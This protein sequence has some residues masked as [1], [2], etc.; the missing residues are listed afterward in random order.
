MNLKSY[1]LLLIISLQHSLYCQPKGIYVLDSDNGTYRDANIRNYSFVD[2]YVWRTSWSEMES[3]KN[4]FNFD[5]I[6]HIVKKLDAINKKLTIL[7]GAYSIEPSYIPATSG[8]VNY[9]FTNP[10]NNITSTRAVPYDSYLME[11]FQLFLTPLANH[12]IYSISTSSMVALKDHPVLSN[13]ATNIPGLGAIRN[14]NGQNISLHTS[15]PNYTRNLF[16]Q[17]I[18]TYMKTQTNSFPTKNVFIPFYKNI[19]D[20]IS[21]PSLESYIKSELLKNFDGIQ[22]PKISFWQENLAGYIDTSTN[23]FTGLPLTTF[24]TPLLELN[25]N[26]YTMFQMLQGWTTP[27]IAPEKTANSTPFDAMCFAYNTYKAS[28]YEIYVNDIDHPNFQT[29]F[30]NW[31]TLNCSTDNS[32]DISTNQQLYVF[33]NPSSNTITLKGIDRLQKINITIFNEKAELLMKAETS[34]NIDISSLANGV[35]II[36]IEQNSLQKKLKFIKN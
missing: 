29:S 7:F 32:V 31:T 17:S 4:N 20:N 25:N 2:G 9:Q 34:D 8:V 15:L 24:A 1:L 11:R 10:I 22:N 27:F 14:V 13:I 28:Y 26:A 23:T 12:K 35:Y 33:P 21:S 36:Q 18:L 3:T 16:A 6:D 19:S 5:G 30:N